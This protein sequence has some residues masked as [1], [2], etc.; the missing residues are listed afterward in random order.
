MFNEKI[1]MDEKLKN[2]LEIHYSE[3]HKEIR[4]LYPDESNWYE[5]KTIYS[6]EKN[7]KYL[8]NSILLNEKAK[9]KT[10]DIYKLI[11]KLVGVYTWYYSEEII[12]EVIKNKSNDINCDIGIIPTGFIYDNL[13]K[14][15]KELIN[16]YFVNMYKYNKENFVLN[17]YLDKNKRI[18]I[19]EA[20]YII[21]KDE[22][23]DLKK[24][25]NNMTLKQ[26]IILLRKFKLD[27]AEKQLNIRRIIIE[28]KTEIIDQIL[29][30]IIYTIINKSDSINGAKIA[31]IF[32]QNF[33]SDINIPIRYAISSNDPK[34]K[35]VI[36]YYNLLGGQ[37]IPVFIDYFKEKNK[38]IKN[39]KGIN[40]SDIDLSK[41][42]KRK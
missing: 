31:M 10:K 28:Y 34:V 29:K 25:F 24:D 20:Y 4:R 14:E 17:F 6:I 38:L 2:I 12:D 16:K 13:T 8:E 37:D 5:D 42:T 27:D 33:N 18:V 41:K 39:K 19:N 7:I 11:D 21:N 30:Y 15:E 40:L 26:A 23:L 3:Y 9:R 32:A 36:E 35:D 22:I 1:E